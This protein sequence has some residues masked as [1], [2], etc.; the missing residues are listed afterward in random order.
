MI[1]AAHKSMGDPISQ[2]PRVATRSHQKANPMQLFGAS[3]RSCSAY[4]DCGSDAAT[5]SETES[6]IGT[7][8]KRRLT[9]PNL[10]AAIFYVQCVRA[11]S[12]GFDD[13]ILVLARSL[14]VAAAKPA[15]AGTSAP[16]VRR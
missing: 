15:T 13:P 3:E 6:C 1:W 10:A 2:Q 5:R 4:C 11:L 8:P 7:F 9:W 14:A 16:T 12:V